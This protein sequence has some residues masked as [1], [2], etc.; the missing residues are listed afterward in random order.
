MMPKGG[1]ATT[2]SGPLAGDASQ[3]RRIEVE[4]DSGEAH[5]IGPEAARGTRGGPVRV[6][7]FLQLPL[8]AGALDDPYECLLRPG[9]TRVRHRIR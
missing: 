9:H 6:V 5:G 7:G 2:T 3:A 1:L 8:P 4:C